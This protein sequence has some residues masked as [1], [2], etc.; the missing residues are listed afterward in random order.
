MSAPARDNAADGGQSGRWLWVGSFLRT[1]SNYDEK[2]L[3]AMDGQSRW[4][5]G[6]SRERKERAHL[7]ES[8][9]AARV[10]CSHK[11]GRG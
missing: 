3:P 1:L 7:I 4:L 10:A 11:A 8:D 2:L 5:S 6:A 9:F